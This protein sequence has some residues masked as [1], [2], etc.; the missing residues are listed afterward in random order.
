MCSPRG[1][2][3]VQRKSPIPPMGAG[4]A[5]PLTG[6]FFLFGSFLTWLVRA[7]IG[8]H[9]FRGDMPARSG[10]FLT[11]DASLSFFPFFPL[12]FLLFSA[13]QSADG[14]AVRAQSIV[15]NPVSP[16]YITPSSPPVFL[17]LIPLAVF[18]RVPLMSP[19][20]IPRLWFHFT[21]LFFPTLL[22]I[23]PPSG[24]FFSSLLLLPL[25]PLA[26]RTRR[27]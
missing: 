3:T 23:P 12:E 2:A 5:S 17:P 15:R 13:Y 7:D 27:T 18:I 25:L 6:D 19:L 8:A 26:D 14:A 11:L 1:R 22:Q 4:S 24:P 16:Q 20:G 10:D 21:F 9:Y